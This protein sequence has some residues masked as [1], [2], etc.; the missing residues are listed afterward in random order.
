MAV[1]IIE[2]EVAESGR[3]RESWV[4]ELRQ[5]QGMPGVPYTLVLDARALNLTREEFFQ[6]CHDN[7]DLRIELSAQGDLIIMSPTTPE[8]GRRNA[9]LT[10][11]LGAWT[12]QDSTGECFDSS[13]MFTL[14]NGAEVSPDASWIRKERYEALTPEERDSFAPIC[15]EFVVELRSKTDQLSA[16]QKKLRQYIEQGARLGW[17]IDPSTKRVYVYRPQQEMEC[18]EQPE[19]VAGDPVLPGFVLRLSEIW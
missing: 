15:P 11:Q 16:L 8:S 6:F 9:K 4:E 7:R 18:L 17:L 12:I 14:P 13:T 10:Y 3:E 5:F 2:N 19:I 1:Q